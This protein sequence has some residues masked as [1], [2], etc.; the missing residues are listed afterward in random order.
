LLLNTQCA[1]CFAL[2]SNMKLQS[3][4][5]L[6]M[7]HSFRIQISLL[8]SASWLLKSQHRVKLHPR[9]LWLLTV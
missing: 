3:L 6:F 4:Y 1:K 2:Q 7:F 8:H 9:P 5:I